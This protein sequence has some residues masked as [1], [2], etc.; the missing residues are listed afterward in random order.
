MNCPQNPRS[1]GSGG[2]FGSPPVLSLGCLNCDHPGHDISRCMKPICY[3]CGTIWL[4]KTNPDYHH[5]TDCPYPQ[6]RQSSSLGKRRNP[7]ATHESRAKMSELRKLLLEEDE[8]TQAKEQLQTG[9]WSD[10]DD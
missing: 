4:S 5:F 6:V 7:Y 9:D 10:G 3:K 1:E 8:D 2:K